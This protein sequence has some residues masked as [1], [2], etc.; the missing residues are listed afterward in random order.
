MLFHELTQALNMTIA[1]VNIDVDQAEVFAN[2]ENLFRASLDLPQRVG[3][4]GGTKAT[5]GASCFIAAA[6]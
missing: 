1:T 5:P 3:H 6:A 4:A 2:K